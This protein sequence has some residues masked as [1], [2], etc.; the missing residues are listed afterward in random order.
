MSPLQNRQDCVLTPSIRCRILTKAEAKRQLKKNVAAADHLHPHHK[1]DTAFGE[2]APLPTARMT[3]LTATHY[4]TPVACMSVGANWQFP[5]P[6][7]HLTHEQ[8][9]GL[10]TRRLL[11]VALPPG[12]N[13]ADWGVETLSAVPTAGPWE[14]R[15]RE[16]QERHREGGWEREVPTLAVVPPSPL[17]VS[18]LNSKDAIKDGFSSL[19]ARAKNAREQFLKPTTLPTII[20]S[21]SAP[22]YSPSVPPSPPPMT[23]ATS[24]MSTAEA[25]L[26]PPL[27]SVPSSPP[28]SFGL[29][30]ARKSI[31]AFSI[32]SS[33][34]VASTSTASGGS[35]TSQWMS[36][37][38]SKW[39]RS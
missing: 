6:L 37:A 29:A 7:A 19:F 26:S 2:D 4:R 28:L 13:A 39:G 22:S 20:S 8:L 11:V 32:R 27:P 35:R 3:E 17:L 12:Q 25:P 14:H 5:I 9:T 23:T 38:S 24:D 30:E 15:G 36:W 33:D 31:D 18:P 10:A 16:R 21:S 1:H 34:T